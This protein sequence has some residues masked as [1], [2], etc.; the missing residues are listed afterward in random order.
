[1]S[2]YYVATFSMDYADE[3]DVEG[4]NTY[5]E[6]EYNETQKILKEVREKCDPANTTLYIGFGSNQELD[7]TL[8]DYIESI[9][10]SEITE[11]EYKA[12]SKYINGFGLMP[13]KEVIE[14]IKYKLDNI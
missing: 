14:S 1:M 9:N 11:T 12:S 8:E 3:F 6:E 10:F 4:I 7:S 2:K 5:T 13:P